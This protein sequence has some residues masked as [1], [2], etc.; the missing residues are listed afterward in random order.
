MEEVVDGCGGGD[1]GMGGGGRGNMGGGRSIEEEHKGLDGR[2]MGGGVKSQA[3]LA[4]YKVSIPRSD[5][6]ISEGLGSSAA[7]GAASDVALPLRRR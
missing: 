5:E 7:S 3:V 4:L 2:V 1:G 6:G